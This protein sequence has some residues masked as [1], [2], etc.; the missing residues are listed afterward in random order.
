MYTP[1][2]STHPLPMP[3]YPPVTMATFLLNFKQAVETILT[4]IYKSL[5]YLYYGTPSLYQFNSVNCLSNSHIR[6][7]LKEYR[8]FTIAYRFIMIK[9]FNNKTH[10][11]IIEFGPFIIIQPICNIAHLFYDIK[12]SLSNVEHPIYGQ[13]QPFYKIVSTVLELPS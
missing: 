10:P 4:A 8:H 7:L 3:S 6:I 13:V 9:P 1:N 5:F 2:A 12:Q 11:F